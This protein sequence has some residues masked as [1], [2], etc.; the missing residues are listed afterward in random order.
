MKL[1]FNVTQLYAAATYVYNHTSP[2]LDNTIEQIAQYLQQQAVDV[3]KSNIKYAK[4]QQYDSLIC[5]IS[6]PVGIIILFDTTQQ[7]NDNTTI[8]IHFL[9]NPILTNGSNACVYTTMDL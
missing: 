5:Y 2:G 4:K 7:I 9:I 3:T 8:P 6:L 1:Q